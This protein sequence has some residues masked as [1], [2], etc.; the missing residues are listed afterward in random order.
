LN[1]EIRIENNFGVVVKYLMG[2]KEDI[3]D[4]KIISMDCFVVVAVVMQIETRLEYF[5]YFV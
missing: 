4:H 3:A 1:I 2:M 5:V